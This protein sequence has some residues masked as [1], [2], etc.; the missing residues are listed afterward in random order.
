MQSRS[1][2]LHRWLWPIW[3]I[4]SVLIASC[5][6]YKND[7][8][9]FDTQNSS[10]TGRISLRAP[11]HPLQTSRQ[12]TAAFTLTGSA[13]AG[14]LALETPL[15]STLA[16]AQWDASAAELIQGQEVR[17]YAH[18]DELTTALTGNPV[19]LTALFDW[20]QGK[21]TQLDGWTPDL[22]QWAQGRIRATMHGA[23]GDTELRVLL[24]TTTP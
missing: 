5:A 4:L 7:K 10:W 19:P 11:G 3:L 2:F 24:D 14:K 20:I 8:A 21:P 16:V 6:H 13:Q 12:F 23:M 9:S 18:M 15:G 17:R 1:T 22:T